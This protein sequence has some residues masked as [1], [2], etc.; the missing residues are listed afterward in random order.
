MTG[1]SSERRLN[2]TL[3]YIRPVRCFIWSL[4]VL[5]TFKRRAGGL[6][7]LSAEQEAI[8]HAPNFLWSP[9]A[10]T[11]LAIPHTAIANGSTGSW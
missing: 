5:H 3:H 2:K 1:V 9:D 4:A 10:R 6:A 8:S 11:Q 7:T